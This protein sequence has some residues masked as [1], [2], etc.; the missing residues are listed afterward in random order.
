MH[1]TGNCKQ[2]RSSQHRNCLCRT[3]EKHFEY[4]PKKNKSQSKKRLSA[5]VVDNYIVILMNENICRLKCIRVSVSAVLNR[6]RQ[7]N[8]LTSILSDSFF[9]HTPMQR[10]YAIA[11]RIGSARVG[12]RKLL[13]SI[14]SGKILSKISLSFDSSCTVT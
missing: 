8:A 3:G 1:R 12:K 10:K 9:M 7:I 11:W 14:S 2:I 5:V 13:Y 4:V 6:N